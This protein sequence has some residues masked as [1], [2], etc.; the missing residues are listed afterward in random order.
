LKLCRTEEV[1]VVFTPTDKAMYPRNGTG[2]FSTYVVEERLSRVME[3]AS[4]RTHFRERPLSSRS[5][6]NII[7]PSFAVFG[8]KDYQQAVIMKRMARDLNFPVEIVVAPICRESDGLAMSS[9]NKYLEGGLRTQAR[10]LW[11]PSEKFRRFC[12]APPNRF[13]LR[14]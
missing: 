5:F 9:R 8:A 10:V 13:P 7:Q 12:G 4:R 14:H 11:G 3:G 1:D 2:A 6:L